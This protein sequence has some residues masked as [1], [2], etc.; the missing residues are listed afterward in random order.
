VLSAT[1][2]ADEIRYGE[3]L[4]SQRPEVCSIQSKDVN[5]PEQS[6]WRLSM[7]RAAVVLLC[8]LTV[9][10]AAPAP[11]YAHG[12]LVVS[13]PEQGAIVRAP[14]D[15]VSLAFTEKLPQFAFFSVTAPNGAR[16]DEPWS[17]AAPFRLAKPVREYQVVDGVWQPRDFQT[18]F[19]IQVPVTHWPDN[20][21][22]VVRYQSVATDGEEVK[23]EVRFTYLGSIRPAPPGWQAPANQPSPEL[24]AAVG[25]P[26]DD[27]R[28][29][30][31]ATPAAAAPQAA[32]PSDGR[33]PWPWLVPVLIVVAV[34]GLIAL[35]RSGPGA[36]RKAG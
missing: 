20:G 29:Q 23:G 9:V 32:Q 19:P 21:Q 16:V 25:T 4:L 24:L 17:H 11:A 28:Q 18:G 6:L 34:A 10:L 14:V 22:Y 3:A 33:G 1:R 27:G 8:L 15:S 7:R 13:T 35:W 2:S 5:L 30:Q 36:R 12:Q 26:R 31:S